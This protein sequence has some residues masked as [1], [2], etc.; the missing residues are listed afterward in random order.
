M[1]T[2]SFP[3]L[4]FPVC[5]LCVHVLLPSALILLP[6]PLPQSISK[7]P[8]LCPLNCNKLFSCHQSNFPHLEQVSAF[9][10][11]TSVLI[12]ESYCSGCC[13]SWADHMHF[14]LP[15]SLQPTPW[16]WL[17][18]CNACRVLMYSERE[19]V[20]SFI[21]ELSYL[22]PTPQCDITLPWF[23][24]KHSEYHTE[25]F[26]HLLKHSWQGVWK[27]LLANIVFKCIVLVQ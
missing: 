9:A 20:S 5:F 22:Q 8:I 4:S 18:A 21:L 13:W 23:R 19:Q 16:V 12:L 24:T 17:E 1:K 25:G 3:F 2:Y 6:F 11:E 26:V 7:P 14:L 27:I 15:S 10:G